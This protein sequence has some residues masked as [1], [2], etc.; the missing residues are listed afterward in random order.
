MSIMYMIRE[1]VAGFGRAK[2]AAIGSIITMMIALLLLGTFHLVSGV[3]SRAMSGIRERVEM[4]AFLAEPVSRQ[5][6]DEISRLACGLEGVDHCQVVT[7]ED[8]ARIFHEEF[9]ED[10]SRVLDFNPL[11]P[12]VK[13]FLRP[14]YRTSDRARSIRDK[15][16]A[17]PGVEDVTYRQD[18][19]SYLEQGTRTLDTVGLV[20]GIV[21]AVSSVF[22]TSNTIRL[23]IAARRKAIRTMKLV[24][25]SRW[26]V[27]GPFIIEG[28]LQGLIAG[29]LTAVT[30]DVILAFAMG[31]VPKDLAPFFATG[32]TFYGGILLLGIALGSF[33]SLISVRRFISETI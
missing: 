33:G 30:F 31:L 20:L 4:E 3:A 1:G 9:G 16:K 26:T 19:L 32:W 12:S 13:I 28:L 11:P 8:A 25:A 6:V 21:L 5:R 27:R 22:I 2:L 15:I 24:G 7:K 18:M 17:I 10:I 23:T 29:I 14:E